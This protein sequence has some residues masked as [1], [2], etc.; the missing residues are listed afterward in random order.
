MKR[1]TTPMPVESD[2]SR[3]DPTRLW[4]D[5]SGPVTLKH[6][7]LME[8]LKAHYVTT[9]RD[10]QLAEEIELMIKNAMLRRDPTRPHGAD[11][12]CEGTALA[13]IAQSGAG[14]TKA[15]EHFLKDNPF[16]PNYGD[17]R[18]GCPLITV[19]TRSPA[20]LAQLGMATMHGCGY[21]SQTH[22]AE[23]EAWSLARF[24]LRH[25][26]ILISHYAEAQRIIKQQNRAE[27]GKIVE[28]LASLMTDLEWP[29]YL[30]LSGLQDLE[31]L[32]QNDFIDD[33]D[34]Q[35]RESHATLTRR[36]RFVE[37]KSIHPVH[38]RKD[39]DRGVGEY[40]K[41]AGV[42]LKI[43]KEPEMR[44]RI[45]HAGARQFGLFFELL[46]MAIEVCVLSSRKAVT[47]QDFEAAYAARTMQ[48]IE[49]NVFA[50][51]YWREIDTTII[52]HRKEDDEEDQ[53]KPKKEKPRRSDT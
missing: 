32:F 43:A 53:P 33:L 46:V 21:P 10:D 19:Q 22:K 52:Q 3:N 47:L 48:P 28:T 15:M 14:K 9:S 11:N 27:R 50:S 51:N 40:E 30:V 31:K 24:Q 26:N 17:S 34:K 35:A 44:E 41:L 6:V 29:L 7:A 4:R 39:L 37:F 5:L 2:L 49:L 13:V 42:S 23:N 25:Q 45:C 18:G 16:F 20:T 12:R 38:D 8:K 36:T 1:K